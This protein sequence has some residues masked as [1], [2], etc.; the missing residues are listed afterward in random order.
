MV[1]L[2]FIGA[3]VP[4][5]PTTIFLILAAWFFARSSPRLEAWLMHHPRFGATLRNWAGKR[6][7][8]RVRK[9]CG[10]HR[11]DCRLPRFLVWDPSWALAHHCRDRISGRVGRLRPLSSHRPIALCTQSGRAP[12]TVATIAHY[13][14]IGLLARGMQRQDFARWG[15]AALCVAVVHVALPYIIANWPQPAAATAEPP[16]AIMIEMAPMPVAPDTP[17]LDVAVGPQQEMSERSTPSEKSEKPV[18]NTE[19]DPQPSETVPERVAESDIKP[20]D[21]PEI[22]NAEAVLDVGAKKPRPSP[23][24][25]RRRNRQRSPEKTKQ[26]KPQDQS[27]KAAKA[28][29]A[30]KPLPAPRART[31]AAPA[32]GVSSSMSIARGAAWS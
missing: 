20:E 25:W 8:R 13:E 10:L 19:P 17:E 14:R 12:M 3:L 6:L 32:S 18:E 29:S 16:A 9:N 7:D 2:G 5:M 27:K 31:N 4:L 28:T 21:L 11:D 22:E 26:S 24:R 30:P 1:M 23:R 15:T